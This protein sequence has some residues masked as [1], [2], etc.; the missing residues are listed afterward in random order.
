[1]YMYMYIYPTLSCL[2]S[3]SC[4]LNR[5]R[6]WSP[7]TVVLACFKRWCI[8]IWSL[9]SA[10][11]QAQDY[12]GIIIPPLLDDSSWNELSSWSPDHTSSSSSL[13]IIYKKKTAPLRSP[14][15]TTCQAMTRS[16]GAAMLCAHPPNIQKWH[17][18]KT[19]METAGNFIVT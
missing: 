8:A 1:M 15:P 3:L 14:L 13:L 16:L 2:H 19:E 11:T 5:W 17:F 18:P 12:D 9:T 7:S 10:E 4:C 6:R